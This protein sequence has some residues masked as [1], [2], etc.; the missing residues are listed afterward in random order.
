MTGESLCVFDS[1]RDVRD[2]TL[3]MRANPKI[4]KYGPDLT[5]T[6]TSGRLAQTAQ[7]A[8]FTLNVST[9]EWLLS[10]LF[11]SP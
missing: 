3:V 2:K 5:C 11:Q 8:K 4:L 6:C 10:H 1:Y 9:H 7:R